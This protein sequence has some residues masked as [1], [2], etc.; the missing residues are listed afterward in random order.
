M[1]D[2]PSKAAWKR[3]NDEVAGNLIPVD[4]PIDACIKDADG[5]ECKNTDRGYQEPILL[6]ATIQA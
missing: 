1:R 3:L 2:W 6:S 5:T 4:F